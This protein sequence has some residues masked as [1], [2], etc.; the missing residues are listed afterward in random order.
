MKY[1]QK[2]RFTHNIYEVKLSYIC[3]DQHYNMKFCKAQI[4]QLIFLCY[5]L[6]PHTNVNKARATFHAVQGKAGLTHLEE[7]YS[8]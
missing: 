7:L 8:K 1:L 5:I 2:S 6:V 4:R 3:V